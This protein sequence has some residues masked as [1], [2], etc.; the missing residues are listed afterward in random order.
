M[1]VRFHIILIAS[2]IAFCVGFGA[3]ELARHARE[4]DDARLWMAIGAGVGALALSVY[5]W[6][7]LKYGVR[8]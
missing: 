7:V 5:L 6:R 4:P 8:G 1:L 2:G 3:L